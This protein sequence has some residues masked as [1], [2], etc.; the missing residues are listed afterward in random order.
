MAARKHRRQQDCLLVRRS[1]CPGPWW[2]SCG[3]QKSTARGCCQRYVRFWASTEDSRSRGRPRETKFVSLRMLPSIALSPED[4]PYVSMWR[5]Q[6]SGRRI[7]AGSPENRANHG[8]ASEGM[9]G[10]EA[11]QPER[12]AGGTS[13]SS[14]SGV[15]TVLLRG[16]CA[17][18]PTVTQWARARG[19]ISASCLI[20]MAGRA[21][22]WQRG[23]SVVPTWSHSL[24]LGL[25]NRRL[26]VWSQD[27]AQ[28]PSGYGSGR[29]SIALLPTQ[30][31]KRAS[32]WLIGS[33]ALNRSERRIS[34]ELPICSYLQFRQPDD[35]SMS[36]R[37]PRCCG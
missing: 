29:F 20:S 14:L 30:K 31:G 23:I 10:L 32:I 4:L 17:D 3:P 34:I 11:S 24:S 16:T 2:S 21:T 33:S 26:Q 7:F 12:K 27:L 1:R 8:G 37:S 18:G 22:G 25:C 28:S 36:R 35:R 15:V 6:N 13:S 19:G 9:G 5:I